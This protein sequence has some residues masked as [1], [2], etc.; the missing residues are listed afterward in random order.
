MFYLDTL[1]FRKQAVVDRAVDD[2]AATLRV[3]R[4]S[5]QVVRIAVKMLREEAC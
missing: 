4:S 1:L 5:L 2:I 3:P